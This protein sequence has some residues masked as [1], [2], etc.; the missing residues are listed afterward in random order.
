MPKLIET[1]C[2]I[3]TSFVDRAADVSCDGEWGRP[4]HAQRSTTVWHVALV[5]GLLGT[6]AHRAAMAQS[7]EAGTAAPPAAPPARIEVT[8]AANAP[9]R[10]DSVGTKTVVGRDEIRRFGDTQASDVLRRLPGVTVEALPARPAE[11]RLRGMGA[12]YVRVTVNGEAPPPGFSI[13]GL[14]ANLIERIEIDRS[15]S[16]DT[17]GQAIAG[18]INIVLRTVGATERSVQLTGGVAAGRPLLGLEGRWSEK[19]SQWQ[20]YAS[21]SV[22]LDRPMIERQISQ[23][24]IASSQTLADSAVDIHQRM[25]ATS[26][27]AALSLGAQ[28]RTVDDVNLGLDGFVRA[29]TIHG[30]TKGEWAH[31]GPALLPPL[32]RDNV[33]FDFQTLSVQVKP[34]ITMKLESGSKFE[35]V[36]GLALNKKQLDSHSTGSNFSGTPAED[37]LATTTTW[38]RTANLQGIYKGAAGLDFGFEGDSSSTTDRVYQEGTIAFQTLSGPSADEAIAQVRR[39]ALFTQNRWQ[40]GE[41]LDTYLGGRIERIAIHNVLAGAPSTPYYTTIASPTARGAWKPTGTDETEY[42]LALSRTF[43]MPTA[44]DLIPHRAHGTVNGPLEPDEIGNPGLR[45][46]LAWGLDVGYQ[47]KLGRF[48]SLALTLFGRRLSEV[49]ITESF[50]NATG[51]WIERKTNAGRALLYGSE[52]DARLD[53]RRWDATWPNASVNLYLAWNRS[54]LQDVAS[55]NTHLNQQAPLQGKVTWEHR[56]TALGGG[57]WRW[58]GQVLWVGASDVRRSDIASKSTLARQTLDL[59]ATWQPQKELSWKLACTNVGSS[60]NRTGQRMDLSEGQ[61]SELKYERSPVA[62]KLILSMNL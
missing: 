47:Q 8:G 24:L 49:I 51:R 60:P 23:K 59:Y 12:G 17:S 31:S 35:L 25:T 42:T 18:S 37:E 13:E 58:G 29:R 56:P 38:I 50:V 36:G 46:E 1:T 6:M 3:Q 14:A 61:L 62:L 32:A 16:A 44:K 7:T 34:K 48:G 22:Q 4:S 54:R 55:G 20:Q 40:W 33:Q 19:S 43:R 28:Y 45:P 5:F 27:A 52:M 57:T 10:N 39:W 11:V 41:S 21:G 30:V 26:Q 53:L 2:G 15:P 9:T